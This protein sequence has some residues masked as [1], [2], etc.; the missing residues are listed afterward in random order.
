MAVLEELL[1]NAC[2]AMADA[3]RKELSLN[4]EFGADEAI[5][6]LSDTGHGLPDADQETL[7]RRGF[8]TKPQG[9]GYGLYQF[10][11]EVERFGGRLRLYNNSDGPGATA[12]LILKTVNRE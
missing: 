3:K 11:Q 12:E 5:I 8:S 1:T 2:D 9:G 4:I 7:F 10:R 6:T